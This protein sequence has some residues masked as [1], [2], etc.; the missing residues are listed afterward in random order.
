MTN[1]Q[2]AELKAAAERLRQCAILGEKADGLFYDD[3][4]ILFNHVLTDLAEQER[5]E[6]EDAEI[7]TYEQKAAMIEAMGGGPEPMDW[8]VNPTIGQV[9][10]LIAALKGE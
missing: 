7:A 1:E 3:C 8:T 4:K 2:R 6:R 10:R 5:Q 9:R